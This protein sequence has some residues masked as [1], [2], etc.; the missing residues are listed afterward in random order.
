MKVEKRNDHIV[1]KINY[2]FDLFSACLR[3][4]ILLYYIY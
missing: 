2:P 4:F 3:H 1:E